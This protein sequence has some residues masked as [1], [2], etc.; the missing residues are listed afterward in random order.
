MIRLSFELWNWRYHL[1]NNCPFH[2]LREV[3]QE[4]FVC[5]TAKK[6]RTS[7]KRTKEEV[8]QQLLRALL[9]SVLPAMVRLLVTKDPLSS[10]LMIFFYI[11]LFAKKWRRNWGIAIFIYYLVHKLSPR[12]VFSF[13]NGYIQCPLDGRP[14]FVVRVREWMYREIEKKY[15]CWK[16]AMICEI[17]FPLLVI[18]YLLLHRGVPVLDYP[19][20]SLLFSSIS[21]ETFSITFFR[22][23]LILS[24]S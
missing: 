15:V 24:V 22:Q 21:V 6:E 10:N 1:D 19:P 16:G 4:S 5:L 18:Y 11:F 14:L 12:F 9:L 2:N 20:Q 7:V 17:R 13:L 23:F 8:L 3:F